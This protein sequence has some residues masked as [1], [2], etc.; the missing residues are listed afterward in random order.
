[1]KVNRHR[2]RLA[3]TEQSKAV[4]TH[5]TPKCVALC[6]LLLVASVSADDPKADRTTADLVAELKPSIVVITF[7]GRD[8][9][10]EG[11]GTGFVVGEDGLIA[12]N[13]HVIGEGRPISVQFADG[14]KRDVIEIRASDRQLD[15]AVL[16]IDQKGLKPL[17]LGRHAEGESRRLGAGHHARPGQS[18]GGRNHDLRCGCG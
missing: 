8:G 18:W 4:L 13:F 9:K 3:Q 14:T 17:E 7:S 15:L 11:L 12:T 1:M 2:S 16:K 5:R 10:Q 6:L